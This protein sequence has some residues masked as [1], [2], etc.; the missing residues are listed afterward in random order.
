MQDTALILVIILI[1]VV[2]W[3][4]PRTLPK[5]GAMLGRGIRQARRQ[6]EAT[7]NGQGIADPPA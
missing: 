5:L 3:R 4:G 7:R 6:V 1:V 2:V